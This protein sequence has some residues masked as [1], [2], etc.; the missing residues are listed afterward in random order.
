MN[1]FQKI[2]FWI[3][4]II[5][6]NIVVGS[7][8]FLGAQ[9]IAVLCGIFAPFAWLLCGAALLPLVL[10][11]AHL[12]KRFP[13]AGGLYVYS[14]KTIGQSWG[15]LSGWGYF[16]GTVAGNAAMIHAFSV[17]VQK[18]SLA[19]MLARFGLLGVGLDVLLIFIFTIFNLMNIQFLE[20]FQVLF[21]IF[22]LVPIFVLLVGALMLFD[23]SHFVLTPVSFDSIFGSIPMIFF[24]YVGIEACCAVADKIKNGKEQVSKVI[25]VSFAAIIL[26]YFML[27]TFIFCIHGTA[28]INPFLNVLGKLTNNQF[29]IS[30][31]NKVIYLSILSS[32]LAGFYGMFYYNNWNLYAIAQDNSIIGSSYLLKK[33]GNNIPWICVLVQ[34]V[35]L[36]TF[37]FIT[38]SD[39]YLVTMS[40][41]GVT[42]AYLLSSIAFFVVNK[43]TKIT[44]VLALLSCIALLYIS[45]KTLY[46]SGFHH[47]LPF[48]ALIV[49]GMVGY[50]AKLVLKERNS[51]KTDY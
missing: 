39:H 23:S 9:R 1:D 27:Q 18:S 35:L 28:D 31:G 20:G 3:A 7:A 44:G 46:I 11:L 50:K 38:T 42:I 8:F 5:N 40:D 14:R 48:L 43:K 49:V 16:I 36:L 34:F 19:P 29:V 26:M 13:E 24:A 12:A 21:A 37:L 51:I 2:P 33:N 41:F 25:L 4:I 22:K 32:F 15:F 45:V 17:Y 10:V 6:I 30:W 47:L